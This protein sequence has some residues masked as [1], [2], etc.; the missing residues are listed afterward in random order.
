MS[1]RLQVV[2]DDE[3]MAAVREVARRQ[4]L[5]VSGWVRQALRRGR[6]SASVADP[7]Q[8][9]AAVRAG[10]RHCFPT[11][12]IDQMLAEIERGYADR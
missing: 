8:K 9:L 1:K 3:E 10:A 2:L 6:S 5:T 4:G 11:A 7:A 12:D